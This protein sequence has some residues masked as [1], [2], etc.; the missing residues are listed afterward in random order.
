LNV[1][2]ISLMC[3]PVLRP[4]LIYFSLPS[5]QLSHLPNNSLYPFHGHQ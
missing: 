5:Q 4:P 1:R 2:G 3:T